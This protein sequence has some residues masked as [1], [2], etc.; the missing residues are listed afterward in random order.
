MATKLP[1]ICFVPSAHVRALLEQVSTL[2]GQSMASLASEMLDEV[3]PV[4][5]GQIDALMALKATPDKARQYVQDYATKAIHD[6]A[7]TSMDFAASEDSRTAEGQ[8][9]RRRAARAARNP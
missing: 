1:R 3:A 6:I 4:V 9:A 2:T 7:Q 5:Q 8:K